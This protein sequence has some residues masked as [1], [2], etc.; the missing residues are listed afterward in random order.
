MAAHAENRASAM[1]KLNK[2]IRKNSR[3]LLP[4]AMAFLLVTFLIPQSVQSCN[5]QG[6]L[7]DI[8]LGHSDVLGKDI[9]TTDFAKAEVERKLVDRFRM[10]SEQV[11]ALDYMLLVNE[12]KRA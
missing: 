7:R 2:F 10:G 8:K 5:K 4:I 11:D 3:M 12:A 1:K 6:D 9:T